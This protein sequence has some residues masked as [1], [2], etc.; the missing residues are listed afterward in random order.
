MTV[1][2]M[3]LRMAMICGH[4]C[5]TL[6]HWAGHGLTSRDGPSSRGGASF[7]ISLMITAT[8]ILKNDINVIKHIF[9]NIIHIKASY[10]I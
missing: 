9:V 1:T 4:S 3:T 2:M 5:S 10:D 7:V 6:P 8:T